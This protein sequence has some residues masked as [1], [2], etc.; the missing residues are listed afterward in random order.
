MYTGLLHTHTLSVILFLFLYLVKLTL[1]LLNQFDRLEKINAWTKIPERVISVLF[2]LTG[3]AMLFLMGEGQFNL[4]LAVKLALVVL[5]I[6]IA[7]MGFRRRSKG[8]AVFAV[9][10]IVCVYG[11]AEMRK[12]RVIKQPITSTV[13][14]NVGD[15]AYEPAAHGKAL[16]EANCTGCHGE[17]GQLKGSG[18]KD[19]TQSQLNDTE[20]RTVIRQG[21][22]AMAGYGKVFSDEEIEALLVYL[23]T[24]R[25]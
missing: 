5:S 10:L 7:V 23:K 21:K 19:L 9:F 25:S 22:N 2:L 4:L 8:L 20:I 18:A 6:P 13:V 14:T 3:V 1:L 15:P 11:I 24:F 17:N 12:A 16:F